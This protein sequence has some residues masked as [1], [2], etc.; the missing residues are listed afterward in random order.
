M[1]EREDDTGFGGR[2]ILQGDGFSYGV[3]AVLL[4]AFA[5]GETG[6]KVP[7]NRRKPLRFMDL[8]TG[9]GILPLVLSYKWRGREEEDVFFGIE[10]NPEAADRARRTM[11]RN[12]LADRITILEG[13]ILEEAAP[14]YGTMDI[15]VSNPPYF[16]ASLCN[17][18]E[19]LRDAR[20]ETTAGIDDFASVA[21]KLLIRRGDFY[22][23]HRPSRLADIFTALRAHRLEPKEMQ[24]VLPRREAA[25]NLVL[26]HA[27]KDAGSELKML[28]DLV[29][30]EEGGGYTEELLRLYDRV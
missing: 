5:S 29:V 18:E 17:D 14:Y 7:S 28:P 13:D 6:A 1:I 11:E 21:S 30:H 23:V 8:G 16:R 15:V 9:N 27:V 12:H 4:A 19:A 24:F 22:L 25:A 10:K 26:I 20:H 2:M 3:D